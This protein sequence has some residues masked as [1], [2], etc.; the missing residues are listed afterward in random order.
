MSHHCA[1]LLSRLLLPWLFLQSCAFL[2]AIQVSQQVMQQQKPRRGDLGVEFWL[3][4][5]LIAFRLSSWLAIHS[6]Y[7]AE[8]DCGLFVLRIRWLHLDS[9][10]NCSGK[11]ERLS[12]KKRSQRD[13][14]ILNLCPLCT[15]CLLE[16][17][18]AFVKHDGSTSFSDL[19]VP[20]GFSSI[21]AIIRKT[22]IRRTLRKP[23]Y[24]NVYCFIYVMIKKRSW[25]NKW[26]KCCW[27]Q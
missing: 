22:R 8:S 2:E 11:T 21:D 7:I 18:D 15:A 16:D 26:V 12:G 14:M 13:R 24:A 19:L 1:I 17:I 6:R 4:F 10:L 5:S 3:A 9:K 25:N 27:R 20:V 23:G